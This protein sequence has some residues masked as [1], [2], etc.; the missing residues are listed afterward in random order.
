MVLF[1]INLEKNWFDD[2]EIDLKDDRIKALL[3]NND[4]LNLIGP[5]KNKYEER[6][7]EEIS[8]KINTIYN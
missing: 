3:E 2:I 7:E 4:E 6:Y 5:K 8:K 1:K